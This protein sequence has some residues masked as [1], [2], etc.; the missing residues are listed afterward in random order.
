[1]NILKSIKGWQSADN[2]AKITLG[3]IWNTIS[4]YIQ[5]SKYYRY[6]LPK[7]KLEQVYLRA[8]NS[9]ECLENIYCKSC[10]CTTSKKLFI[11]KSC[12]RIYEGKTPCYTEFLSKKDWKELNIP[13]EIIEEG[14]KILNSYE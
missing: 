1:M 5:G 10:G 3:N 11:N 7:Y 6:I 9:Q 8:L 2:P 13:K 14:K 12:A 4:G